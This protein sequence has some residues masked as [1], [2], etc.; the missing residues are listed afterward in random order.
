MAAASHKDMGDEGPFILMNQK[1]DAIRLCMSN[2][3]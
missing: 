3:I 1:E 2:K